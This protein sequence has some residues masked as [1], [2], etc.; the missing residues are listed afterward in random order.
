MVLVSLS[1]GGCIQESTYINYVELLSRN[2]GDFVRKSDNC[3]MVDEGDNPYGSA[4]SE[5][6]ADKQGYF[7]FTVR[8]ADGVGIYY[9]LGQ[10]GPEEDMETE[11]NTR[12][13]WSELK[14][15]EAKSTRFELSEDYLGTRTIEIFHYGSRGDCEERDFSASPGGGDESGD[16][17]DSGI[18]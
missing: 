2:G 9:Y 4:F 13:S 8:E 11:L 5:L 17:A 14:A 10:S 12:F 7:K 15:G 6:G 1:L 16:D 18:P 3:F